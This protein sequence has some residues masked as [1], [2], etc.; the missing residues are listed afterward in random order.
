MDKLKP[1]EILNED[2]IRA[3]KDAFDAYDKMGYGTLE[4]EEL[5]KVLEGRVKWFLKYLEF[6]QKPTR[7]DLYK[8]ISQVDSSN[9]GYVDFKDFLKAIAIYKLIEEDNEEDDTRK[10]QRLKPFASGRLRGDGREPRQERQRGGQQT[11]PNHQIGFQDDDRHRE[12]H[13]RN[14]SG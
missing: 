2:E 14:G 6:G 13:Q 9:K 8:M 5:Q 10:E 4:V 3:S 1:E 7:E 11:H 12:T